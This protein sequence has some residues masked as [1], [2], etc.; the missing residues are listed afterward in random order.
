MKD[1]V[2]QSTMS[3]PPSGRAIG[4]GSGTAARLNARSSTNASVH[5]VRVTE[6]DG[7]KVVRVTPYFCARFTPDPS[8]AMLC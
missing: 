7:G 4:V 6:F 5:M 1:D 2:L 3:N 8:G